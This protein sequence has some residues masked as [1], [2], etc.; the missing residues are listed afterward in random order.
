MDNG[1][2]QRQFF[3]CS[4][5]FVLGE[6]NLYPTVLVLVPGPVEKKKLTILLS[7]YPPFPPSHCIELDLPYLNTF[8]TFA[9]RG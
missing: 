5:P 6:V 2:L 9:D 7:T 8:A 4:K 1:S 3:A